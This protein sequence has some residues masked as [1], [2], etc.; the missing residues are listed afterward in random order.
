MNT[1]DR[2]RERRETLS[3]D[4]KVALVVRISYPTQIQG[5]DK[6]S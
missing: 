5:W 6:P 3:S 4:W 1:D 2:Q